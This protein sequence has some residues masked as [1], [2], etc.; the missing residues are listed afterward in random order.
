MSN[1]P[2]YTNDELNARVAEGSVDLNRL[3]AT[4]SSVQRSVDAVVTWVNQE[5]Q[6][7][8]PQQATTTP[9]TTTPTV[10]DAGKKGK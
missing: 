1:V 5:I 7:R 3:A 2:T 4:L 9:T 8:Q 10:P 6:S